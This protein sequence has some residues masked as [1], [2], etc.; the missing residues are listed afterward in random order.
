[1]QT[2]DA[3]VD[4][5]TTARHRFAITSGESVDHALEA[6]QDASEI[7]DELEARGVSID[8]LRDFWSNYAEAH[9]LDH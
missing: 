4:N 8:K 2:T 1:M 6:Q 9:G 5:Y 3:L 7:E